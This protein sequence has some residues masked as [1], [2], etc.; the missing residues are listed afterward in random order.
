ML[1]KQQELKRNMTSD[2]FE[3]LFGQFVACPVGI[4]NDENQSYSCSGRSGE[5]Q[6]KD[7]G[8]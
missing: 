2:K 5:W 8:T 7:P 4:I 6:N 1:S 3:E